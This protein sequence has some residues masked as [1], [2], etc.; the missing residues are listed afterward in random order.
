MHAWIRQI[1]QSKIAQRGGM[2][3]RK[4]TTIA[5]YASLA[6]LEAEVKKKGFHIVEHGDQYIVFCDKAS[7]R[8]VC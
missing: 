7:V 5:K 4:K 8:V 2:V 1:F 6:Q 3:R